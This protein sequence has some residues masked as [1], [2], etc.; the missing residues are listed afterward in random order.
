MGTELGVGAVENV[1]EISGS[2]GSNTV[3]MSLATRLHIPKWL[4]QN[5]YIQYNKIIKYK[6]IK[7]II[8]YFTTI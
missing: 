4:K 3:D 6:L 2:D 8:L 5:I 7:Y 1:L